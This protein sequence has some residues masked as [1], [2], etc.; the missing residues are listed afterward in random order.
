MLIFMVRDDLSGVCVVGG[1]RIVLLEIL[2]TSRLVFSLIELYCLRLQFALKNG[3]TKDFHNVII[4]D[5]RISIKAVNDE[6]LVNIDDE[7]FYC[8]KD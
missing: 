5:Y 8:Y 6:L 7:H 2:I 3:I 1:C 4:H